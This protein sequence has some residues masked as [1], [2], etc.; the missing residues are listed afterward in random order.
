MAFIGDRM[1]KRVML[2]GAYA[3]QAVGILALALINA[4]VLGFSLGLL[5]TPFYVIGFGLGFGMS[6]PLRLTILADYFG[7]RSYG[8]ILGI[9]SSVN[10]LFG[11]G[12]ALFAGA[13]FDITGSYRVP[14]LAM[15]VLL[16]LA[17]PLSM[18]RQ[19]RERVAAIARRSLR[20]VPTGR[21]PDA[22]V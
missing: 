15:A 12:G 16:V 2:A 7:R 1:D 5:P 22:G 14:F 17:V 13:M 9:T 3:I 10:A 11:A 19:S 21:G 18:S 6:I 8:S 20:R 4:E